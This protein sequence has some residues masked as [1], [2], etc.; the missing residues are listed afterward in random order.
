M[1]LI[2]ATCLFA[3][4]QLFAQKHPVKFGK[5]EMPEMEMT[6]YEADPD[7]DG[8]YLVKYAYS[9]YVSGTDDIY[10]LTENHIRIKILDARAIDDLATLSLRLYKSASGKKEEITLWKASTFNLEN[11]EIVEVKADKSAIFEEKINSNNDLFRINMPAVREGSV[12]DITYNVR[13]DFYGYLEPWVFQTEYPVKYS[14]IQ[15]LIPEIFEWNFYL[16]GFGIPFTKSKSEPTNTTSLGYASTYGNWIAENIPA[17]KDEPYVSNMDNYVSRIEFDLS[18]LTI[19]GRVY[20]DLSASWN[21]IS[22]NLTEDPE[23]GG[24]L[25]TKNFMEEEMARAATQFENETERTDHIY[26][27]VQEHMKW[28][29][30]KSIFTKNSIETVWQAK[31]GNSAEINLLLVNMLQKAGIQAFPVLCSTVENGFMT[32][33]DLNT[34]NYVFAYVQIGD[35]HIYLDATDKHL[36]AG[37][38]PR[39]SLNRTGMLYLG[40]D[41]GSMIDVVPP[42]THKENTLAIL[43]LSEDGSLQGS[44]KT[45]Y[46]GYAAFTLRKEFEEQTLEEKKKELSD[47]LKAEISLM[48]YENLDSLKANSVVETIQLSFDFQE[49]GQM[50]DRIYFTPMM[51]FRMEENPFKD[52]T[53]MFPIEFPFSNEEQV[54]VTINLPEGYVLEEAPKALSVSLPEGGGK[55]LFKVESF[56]KVIQLF[57]Q[58]TIKKTYFNAEDYA[59]LKQFFEMVIAKEAEPIVLK[60]I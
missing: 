51:Q 1:A 33:P 36:P 20:R 29:E 41:Q 3:G 19:P 55:F 21:V 47:E 11:G 53:R 60:K 56:D 13:S 26:A 48:E 57:T 24:Y 28:N 58:L 30:N 31:N 9:T 5:I 18:K 2:V 46:Y 54:V 10:L 40:E 39:R 27:L 15:L 49:M 42:A 37:M 12:L 43:N 34:M 38:L 59:L 7:A 25:R 23:F 8:V 17:A 6:S 14:E 16:R 32:R 52:E 45:Q 44:V 4:N 22:R 35:K 50:A